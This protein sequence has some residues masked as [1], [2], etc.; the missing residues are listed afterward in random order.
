MSCGQGRGPG[1]PS[2][3][4]CSRG[5]RAAGA[6]WP[7]AEPDAGDKH[8]LWAGEV[9][10]RAPGRCSLLE[11]PTVR[12]A[13][14]MWRAPLSPHAGGRDGRHGTTLPGRDAPSVR[15]HPLSYNFKKFLTSESHTCTVGRFDFHSPE[16]H[17]V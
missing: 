14:G 13:E 15:V 9:S 2:R 3:R 7:A 12:G 17:T 4:L 11:V 16:Q 10:G 5:L 6:L 8:V 1:H